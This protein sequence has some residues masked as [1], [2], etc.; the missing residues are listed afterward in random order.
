[1]QKPALAA[2]SE[3]ADRL[4]TEGS[5]ADAL[6]AVAEAA[7]AATGADLAVLRVVEDGVL[8]TRG[9]AGPAFLI[10]E[11]VG[12]RT[13]EGPGEAEVAGLESASA[14]TKAVPARTKANAV[15]IVPVRHEGRVA[16]SLELLRA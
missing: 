13:E 15:F 1:M 12:S 5:V 2:L 8:V 14:A 11:I 4:A 10:A 3:G 9:V 7:R 6:R 16:G